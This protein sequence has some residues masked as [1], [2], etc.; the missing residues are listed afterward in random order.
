MAV[1]FAEMQK[2]L[3]YLDTH[4]DGDLSLEALTVQTGLSRFHL[5]R[6]FARAIGETPGRITLRLRLGRAALFLLAGRDSILDVALSCGFQS[7]EAFCRAF[8]RRFA[9]TPRA[10]RK[11]GFAQRLDARQA[12]EHVRVATKIAPCLG[13][14]RMKH[15]PESEE[16]NMTYSVTKKELGAQ[17]VLVVRRRV[18]RSDIPSTIAEALPQVF[19]YAQQHGIALAGVPF[20]RYIEMGPGLVTMEPGMRM[21]VPL[22]DLKSAGTPAESPGDAMVAAATLPGGPVAT[23]MHVGPYESLGEAY[24]SL[25]QWMEGQGLTPGGAPWECYITDPAEYPD[26]KDWKTEVFWPLS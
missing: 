14:Y 6:I 12:L 3:A 16:N 19:A 17:P 5:H 25:Q 4:L 13:L 22:E 18:K 1:R 9:M 11:R 23:T 24:A 26:P 15:E 7:H 2:V 8:R 20:T 10:Y 21:A